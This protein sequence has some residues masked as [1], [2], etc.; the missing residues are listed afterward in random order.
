[1]AA[2]A[3]IA[4]D[5]LAKLALINT[6]EFVRLYEQL[7][8]KYKWRRNSNIYKLY[9]RAAA[10]ETLEIQREAIF[11]DAN[12]TAY[13]EGDRAYIKFMLRPQRQLIVAIKSRKW[14]WN[15][16]KNAW[17]TYLNRV[18]KDWIESISERYTAYI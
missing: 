7:Q 11:E 17:S 16:Y 8:P 6:A 12:F 1:M 3:L 13:I 4:E 2:L 5:N 18:D 14:W 10:G 15:G 9:A